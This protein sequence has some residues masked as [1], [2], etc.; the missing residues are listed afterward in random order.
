MNRKVVA[1]T[2][3]LVSVLLIG[4]YG[5]LKPSDA[6]PAT[7]IQHIVF[8]VQE[9]HS[10]DNY[11]GTYPGA[12]GDGNVSVL[13]DPDNS[14]SGRVSP[15]HISANVAVNTGVA[16]P[17][18]PIDTAQGSTS[19]GGDLGHSWEVAHESYNG[20]KMDGFIKADNSTL[21]MGYYDRRD[22]P[23]YWD[24]ADHYV[25]DDNFFASIMGPSLPTHLYIASGRSGT[26]DDG[27]TGDYVVNGSVINNPPGY[28][29][30]IY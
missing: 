7:K 18:D 21:C 5:S 20:G 29:W 28:G 1:L 3:V 13:I 23:Y 17:D 2:I 8:I 15:F 14:A 25:L 12:N 22:I 27:L 4:T 6:D 24:Y 30:M 26:A 16:D 11:F 19:L 10:F 9:N